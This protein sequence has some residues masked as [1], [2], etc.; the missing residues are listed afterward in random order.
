[1]SPHLQSSHCEQRTVTLHDRSNR[2]EK[3]SKHNA[4]ILIKSDLKESAS[5]RFQHSFSALVSLISNLDSSTNPRNHMFT[6]KYIEETK[7]AEIKLLNS[8]KSQK[9]R[10]EIRQ[11]NT[12]MNRKGRGTSR[13]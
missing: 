7:R 9:A 8:S 12:E 10:L 11:R 2:S 13:Q 3:M 6:P 5:E 4:S 1:M